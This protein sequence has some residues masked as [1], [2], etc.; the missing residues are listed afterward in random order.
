MNIEKYLE[1]IMRITN[2]LSENEFI[3]LIK[4]AVEETNCC[5]NEQFNTELVSCSDMYSREL[6]QIT[7]NLSWSNP[8]KK[9]KGNNPLKA[10]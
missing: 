5:E 1:E 6:S 10:A 9:T 4:K 2:R 7:F 8:Y 3:D